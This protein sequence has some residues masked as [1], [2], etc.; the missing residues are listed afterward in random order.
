VLSWIPPDRCGDSGMRYQP[1]SRPDSEHESGSFTLAVPFQ[2]P[3]LASTLVSR[4]YLKPEGFE[5]YGTPSNEV[6]EMMRQEAISTG[7]TLSIQPDHLAGPYR[8]PQF[9]GACEHRIRLT[10]LVV[11]PLRSVPFRTGPVP[12]WRGRPPSPSLRRNRS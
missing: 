5:I 9:G 4:E 10:G 1:S 3:R 6:L 2:P 8:H 11:V 7:V 12:A